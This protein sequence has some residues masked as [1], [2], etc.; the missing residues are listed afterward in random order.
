MDWQDPEQVLRALIFLYNRQTED[1]KAQGT[2]VHDNNMGFNAVDAPFLTSVAEQIVYGRREVSVKQFDIV[3]RTIQKYQKQ[4]IYEDISAISLPITCELYEATQVD[5]DGLLSVG[6][7][8]GKKVL[9]FKPNTF[10]TKQI[11]EAGRFS[12]SDERCWIGVLSPEVIRKVVNI[13]PMAEKHE[14]IIEWET[15]LDLAPEIDLDLANSDLFA[16]QKEATGFIKQAGRALLGLAPGLG[17]SP[18][19]I[20]AAKGL[21]GKTLIVCPLSLVRNWQKEIKKWVDEDAQIWHGRLGYSSEWVITNYESILSQWIDYDIQESR[22]KNGKMVKKKVNWECLVDHDFKNL[23]IDESIMIKNR[24]AQR[25][26]AV[27]AIAATFD[28]V[29]LLS[30]APT[31]KYYN[32]LWS[33]LNIL[34]PDRFSAYWRFTQDYC[35]VE[36]THWGWQIT[37]NLPDADRMIKQDLRD[38]FFSRTQDQVLDL[39]PWVFDDYDIDMSAGQYKMY[40]QMEEEFKAE[41]PDGDVLIAPNLLS[42]MTRLIQFA[43]NPVL[44]GGLDQSNK[45]NAIREILEFERLPAIVWTE[46]VKTVDKMMNVLSR[47]KYRLSALTGKT[48]TDRRQY[49]VD[50]FQGGDLDVI[51]AHPGVGKFGFNLPA[52][53]TAIYLERSYNGDD[54]YQSLHRVRRIGT[55]ESPHVIHL[56]STRPDN[57]GATI[58]HVIHAV[59]DY[60]TQS[61]IKLTSGLVREVL[62]LD[63]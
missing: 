63:Y 11:K 37:A 14:S 33:Q 30:G 34:D 24:K 36:K 21:G 35:H 20:Y 9:Q 7:K 39:P 23:I 44:V 29:W 16:F 57:G 46:Y 22:N 8:N 13:F 25:T 50:Q 3:V 60:K 2:T 43:S 51:I 17:K 5:S 41:L 56:R 32:D 52:A 62:G 28:R 58:D 18:V 26:K 38:I 45:W 15:N 49:I 6:E 40:R 53:R 59:L 4:W 47:K 10:P 12:W 31:S 1:E 42:Q 27:G 48:P 55:T 54:Y 19:S 61:T